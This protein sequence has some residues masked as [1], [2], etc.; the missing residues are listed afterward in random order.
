MITL[1]IL[2]I[3]NLFA[4]IFNFYVSKSHFSYD[5]N[6]LLIAGNTIFTTDITNDGI[7]DAYNFI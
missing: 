3:Y 4:S 5:V 7:N 2:A 1:S 6:N